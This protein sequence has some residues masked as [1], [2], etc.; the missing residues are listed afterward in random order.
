MTTK[1][2]KKKKNK[3]V[4]PTNLHV[5]VTPANKTFAATYGRKR[6]NTYSQYVNQLIDRDRIA[7]R[8]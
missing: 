5:N 6:F 1:K 7:H 3:S 8:A 2:V 4:G